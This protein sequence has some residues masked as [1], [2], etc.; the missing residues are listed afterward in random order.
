MSTFFFF[1]LFSSSSSPLPLYCFIQIIKRGL[2]GVSMGIREVGG[3]NPPSPPCGSAP[4][5]NG[6]G[7][8]EL[9]GEVGRSDADE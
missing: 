3:L 5:S 8:E 4:D 7:S 1:L 2:R 9:V 6:G